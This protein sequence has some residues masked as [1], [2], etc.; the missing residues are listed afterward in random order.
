RPARVGSPPD[1]E[2]AGSA[3]SR[4]EVGEERQR[5]VEGAGSDR[6]RQPLV[7]LIVGQAALDV[8]LLERLHDT[9]PVGIR[10]KHCAVAENLTPGRPAVLQT[11]PRHTFELSDWEGF[12][13]VSRT[14]SPARPASSGTGPGSG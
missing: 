13:C 6:G 7:E 12:P 3:R 11:N 10:G 2:D 8:G 1:G 9:V 14:S 5:L 4:L